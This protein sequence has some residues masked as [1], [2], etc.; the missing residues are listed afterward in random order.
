[1]A[2][3]LAGLIQSHA[4]AVV[5]R[6]LA[7]ER[8]RRRRR[9]GP[10]LADAVEWLQAVLSGG[11][12]PVTVVEDLAREV[13]ISGRTLQRARGRLGVKSLPDGWQ[14]Q[15]LLVLPESGRIA[16][17]VLALEPPIPEAP[18]VPRRVAVRRVR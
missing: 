12:L 14:G 11:P 4:T 13:G 1:M 2:S 3:R 16:D 15:R 7:E 17:A 9:H 18:A 5:R 6:Q 10:S 8:E